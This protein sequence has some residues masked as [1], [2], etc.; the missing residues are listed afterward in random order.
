MFS[1][2]HFDE[3]G[4]VRQSSEQISLQFKTSFNSLRPSI[5][6]SRSKQKRNDVTEL[7]GQ[8]VIDSAE[9]SFS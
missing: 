8:Q 9:C 3:L 4:Q 6:E 5:L 1:R 2:K 7:D